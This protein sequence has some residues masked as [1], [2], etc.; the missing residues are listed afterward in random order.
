[1]CDIKAT[2][3]TTVRGAFSQR[4]RIF[5]SA[6]LLLHPLTTQDQTPLHPREVLQCFCHTSLENL[7]SSVN[8]HY[9]RIKYYKTKSKKSFLPPIFSTHCHSCACFNTYLNY[10]DFT[11]WS[12]MFS[13]WKKLSLAI[14]NLA[15]LLL[16]LSLDRTWQNPGWFLVCSLVKDGHNSGGLQEATNA[17]A[18]ELFESL[19]LH[20]LTIT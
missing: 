15:S 11:T 7:K 1:M 18:R 13:Q 8:L 20:R 14:F 19:T 17:W 6:L 9:L 3:D 10:V 4:T 16:Q 5:I 2:M 12:S